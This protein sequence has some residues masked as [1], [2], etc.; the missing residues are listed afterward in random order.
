MPRLI[1]VFHS[2]PRIGQKEKRNHA[3]SWTHQELDQ[4]GLFSR[5]VQDQVGRFPIPQTGTNHSS[6]VPYSRMEINPP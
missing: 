4:I 6:L 3:G 2:L 1:L 5:L